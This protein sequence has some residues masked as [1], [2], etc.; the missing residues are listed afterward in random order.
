MLKFFTTKNI[1][2]L[3]KKD[4]FIFLNKHYD[5]LFADSNKYIYLTEQKIANYLWWGYV[6][7]LNSWTTALQLWLLSLWIKPWDEVLLPAN[8]YSATAIAITNIWAK[9]IFVDINLDNYTIDVNDIENK[10]TKKTKAIIAVHIYWYACNMEAIKQIVS[11][12]DIKILEDAS[13]AFWWELKWKKLGTIWNIWAFSCHLSKNFWTYWNGWI[14]YTKDKKT[15]DKLDNYI[16]PDKQNIDVLKSLRTPANIWVMDSIVLLLKLKY[17]D[18]IIEKNL[19]LY[20][21]YKKLYSENDTIKFPK[22]NLEEN[23]LHIRNLVVLSEN[24]EEYIKELLWKQYYDIDLNKSI[25]FWKNQ[26]LPN[27]EKFF[28]QNLWLNFYF[29]KEL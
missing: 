21:K 19:L 23:K 16:F 29:G 10:I 17:I 20:K 14:F 1:N 12:Y 25:V 4:Y 13:H 22:L 27:T 9:A 7:L 3:I 24:R 8:T 18:S 5:N 28:K 11:K 26:N 6:K 15:F 2:K